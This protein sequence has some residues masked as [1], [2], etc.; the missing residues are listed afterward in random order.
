M[1]KILLQLANEF[2]VYR[3]RKITSFSYWKWQQGNDFEGIELSWKPEGIFHRCNESIYIEDC[4]ELLTEDCTER[5]WQGIK[6]DL[7]FKIFS[8]YFAPVDDDAALHWQS[9][10]IDYRFGLAVK[11]EINRVLQWR[12]LYYIKPWHA[13]SAN[14]VLVL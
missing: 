6:F 11:F 3:K 4:T 2:I 5:C 1:K 14:I 12:L 7:Y 10:L 9:L 8:V 13:A